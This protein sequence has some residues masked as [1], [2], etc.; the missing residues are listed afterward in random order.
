MPGRVSCWVYLLLDALENFNISRDRR[1]REISNFPTHLEVNTNDRKH[2][3]S[4]YSICIKFSKPTFCLS[5]SHPA[6][7]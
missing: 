1:S 5:S 7:V 6:K 3:L 4:Q 2:T